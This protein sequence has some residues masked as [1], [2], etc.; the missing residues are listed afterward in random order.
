MNPKDNAIMILRSEKENAEVARSQ[1]L[2]LVS[3]ATKVQEVTT[4]IAS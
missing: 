4:T 1:Y 3:A 2:F